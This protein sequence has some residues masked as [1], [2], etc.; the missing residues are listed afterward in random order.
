MVLV[1]L[2]YGVREDECYPVLSLPW[3]KKCLSCL[4][5]ISDLEK[6]MESTQIADDTQLSKTS[7][8][9]FAH[10]EGPRQTGWRT[11]G[12]QGETQSSVLGVTEFSSPFPSVFLCLFHPCC[13]SLNTRQVCSSLPFHSESHSPVDISPPQ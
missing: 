5:F 8:V 10:S 9:E 1:Y 2:F 12:H 11:G 7:M 4:T 13:L 6:I 3:G